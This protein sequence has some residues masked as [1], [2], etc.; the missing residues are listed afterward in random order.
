MTARSEDVD[1]RLG[2]ATM[3]RPIYCRLL[4][5]FRALLL[6]W[7]PASWLDFVE[8]PE[9]RDFLSRWP[10]DWAEL[11][12][13]IL[14]LPMGVSGLRFV[15]GNGRVVGRFRFAIRRCP[16][17]LVRGAAPGKRAS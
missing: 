8:P 14:P 4:F 9:P 17:T 3:E 7:N 11:S 5:V 2:R 15:T 1:A 12:P 6:S 10:F 13:F 16:A